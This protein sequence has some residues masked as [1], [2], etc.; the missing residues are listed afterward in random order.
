MQWKNFESRMQG[1][2]INFEF[3]FGIKD[4]NSFEFNPSMPP[5]QFRGDPRDEIRIVT[6]Q[7]GLDI[8]WV[9][10]T[11][12]L[13]LGIHLLRKRTDV[14]PGT[15]T[16]VGKIDWRLLALAHSAGKD[17]IDERYLTELTNDYDLLFWI[18]A[19]KVDEAKREELSA[20]VQRVLESI[21]IRDDR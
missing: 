2:V 7:A 13:G 19:D 11:Q 21:K 5:P 16:R 6:M 17:S 9:H 18:S 8:G 1:K 15:V 20:I 12:K 10:V 14:L 3:P 4:K